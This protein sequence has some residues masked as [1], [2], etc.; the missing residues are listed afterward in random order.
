MEIAVVMALVTGRTLVIPPEQDLYLLMNKG[1][2][3]KHK[4]KFSMLDFFHFHSIETEF[5]NFRAISL[6]EFLE[7]QALTGKLLSV[8]DEK[9]PVFPPG[10][11]TDW[12]NLGKNWESTKRGDGKILWR[13]MREEAAHD[14]AWDNSR[15][16]AAFPA[17]RLDGLSIQQLQSTLYEILHDDEIRYPAVP[18]MQ[19]WFRR[20]ERTRGK[21]M[22]VFANVT[23]RMAEMLANRRE[24][25]IYDLKLQKAKV[26]HLKGE[27][28]TGHRL[29]IHFYAFLF[30]QDWRTDLWVKR[31]VR[32]CV[33]YINSIVL[34]LGLSFF[35]VGKALHL[36][37]VLL[38]F[39]FHHFQSFALRR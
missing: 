35:F 21:P 31:F 13:W 16:L 38:S 12:T 11:R 15:C 29:L 14:L 23:E 10:N 25:C 9:T 4:A 19:R 32:E 7:K 6:K 22:P 26:V 30:F 1:N 17:K 24:L 5:T 36:K 18:P 8:R 34:L 33:Y 27:Q 3:G 37:R 28:D 20:T 39:S 2:E